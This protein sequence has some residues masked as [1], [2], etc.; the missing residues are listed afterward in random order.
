MGDR[1]RGAARRSKGVQKTFWAKAKAKRVEKGV[2]Q[3][4]TSPRGRRKK[5]EGKN[6]ESRPRGSSFRPR[7]AARRSHRV[8]SRGC[9]SERKPRSRRRERSIIIRR[10]TRAEKGTAEVG[11][12]TFRTSRG[13]RG[14][15]RSGVGAGGGGGGGDAPADVRVR[16]VRFR[17]RALHAGRAHGVQA[18]AEAL[19]VGWVP[20]GVRLA[21][22]RAL[23]EHRLGHRRA[24]SGEPGDEHRPGGAGATRGGVRKSARAAR[25][26]RRVHERRGGVSV[27]RRSAGAGK[28]TETKD[29]CLFAGTS[30]RSGSHAP[31]AD[32]AVVHPRARRRE[33]VLRRQ[34]LHRHLLERIL[35]RATRGARLHHWREHRGEC[36][37]LRA[38]TFRKRGA[39]NPE[40][41]GF[42]RLPNISGRTTFDRDPSHRPFARF[43]PTHAGVRR[44]QFPQHTRVIRSRAGA[45]FESAHA[46][47]LISENNESFE[48]APST[49]VTSSSRLRGPPP[50]PPPPAPPPAR[51]RPPRGPPPPPA[52]PPPPPPPPG[53]PPAA[54]KMS[55][56]STERIRNFHYFH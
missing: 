12:P 8:A 27:T 19:G 3:R 2:G 50:P 38:T 33:L 55:P 42:H 30:R 31:A 10:G 44:V 18:A 11:P 16:L 4:R 46:S 48:F 29:E 35:H 56:S 26:A 25:S 14:A 36:G 37:R 51:R 5:D 49:K 43:L 41:T 24:A 32:L 6:A 15:A 47:S 21:K 17:G 20:R 39:A 22:E 54:T 34:P 52:P 45:G 7:P 13:R 40:S 9:R 53:P 28:G 1:T 23:G